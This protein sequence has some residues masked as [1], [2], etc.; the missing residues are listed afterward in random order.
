MKLRHILFIMLFLL[1][2]KVKSQVNT[3]P[4]KGKVIDASTG[5]GIADATVRLIKEHVT[6]KTSKDGVFNMLLNQD[7]DTLEVVA[8][9]YERI[10]IAVNRRTEFLNIPLAIQSM[11]LQE[12]LVNTGYQELK[13]NELTGA[14]VKIDERT[15]QQQTSTNILDRLD[16]VVSGLTFSKGKS[17]KNPQ[18]STNI[19]IRGLSTINGPLDPLIVLDGFIYEGDIQNI[20]PDDVQSIN[21]LKDAAAASIWG[22][23]AGNGVIVITTKQGRLNQNLSISMLSS[24]AMSP[25]ANLMALPQMSATDYIAVEQ[26]L[27]NKGYFNRQIRSTPYQA[28]TPAID[29]FQQRKLGLISTADSTAMIGRLKGIDSRKQYLDNFYTTPT[30]QQYQFSI[31]GG[32]V[33]NSYQ[34]S[35]SENHSIGDNY[36][37]FDKQN[38]H[39]GQQFLL[40]SRLKFNWRIQYTKSKSHSGRPAYNSLQINGR[41]PSYLSFRDENG[42]ELPLAFQYAPG[43]TDTTGTGHLLDWNYYPLQEFQHH[44]YQTSL[45]EIYATTAIHYQIFP[46]LNAELDY[47]QQHQSMD[48]RNLADAQSY[49]ARD[50]VNT[51]SQLNRTTGVVSYAIPVGGVLSTGNNQTYSY[52]GRFQLNLDHSWKK[53]RILALGGAEIREVS[54]NGQGNYYYGYQSDPLNYTQIDNVNRYRNWVTKRTSTIGSTPKL[55][56]LTNRFVS[57]YANA[58]YHYQQKY[59]LY[60]SIRRDGSNI[61]G[62]NTNDRWK[63]L[64][65]VGAVW[66]LSKENFYHFSS[67]P[68]LR[69]SGTWG[70]SGN[71]DLSRSALPVASYASNRYNQLPFIRVININNPGLKWEQTRQLNL[72]LDF[73]TK[74]GEFSGSI[75]YY[76]KK[77]TDLYGESPFDYTAW[78]RNNEIVKNVADLKGQGIDLTLNAAIITRQFKWNTNFLFSYNRNKVAAYYSQNALQYAAL[79]GEG[80]RITPVVGYPLYAIAAYK[81]AGLDNQGNPQGYLNGALSTDYNAMRLAIYKNGFDSGTM[82]YYGSAEPLYFGNLINNF[83]WKKWSMNINVGYKFD[84]YLFKPSISYNSLVN[85]GSVQPEFAQRWQHKGDENQTSVP[86]FTLPV[87][88]NRD[89]FY[90]ESQVNVLKGDHLRVNYINLSR[91]LNLTTGR[92]QFNGQVYLNISNPGILWRAN[93]AGVDPDY[94]GSMSPQQ[95]YTLGFRTQFK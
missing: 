40:G 35:V 48:A 66:D 77:G 85:N 6:N 17:N 74:G 8:L 31:R 61:F 84:Y 64:W 80:N 51:Y 55:T 36:E 33:K 59:I 43:Y 91:E 65:S 92:W 71:V 39:A 42:N 76:R 62:A 67:L 26:E 72:K 53:N 4:I 83:S 87:N 23:R 21:V 2:T 70:Y 10:K 7:N 79:L 12:V 54:Q 32:A 68:E 52:T 1:T 69:I 18:N 81:W 30:I 27:F 34:L 82:I 22:A 9:G 73:S 46:F 3:Y 47:Q 15:L 49:Q 41:K 13:S 56:Q 94:V 75:S 25:K 20:N 38:I 29:I 5:L 78:G 14:I 90:Q 58:S 89:A 16:G 63:P 86:S 57:Y 24:V 60:G 88:D 28:L 95:V 19:V 11:V 37:S 93:H 50:L 45:Q 44:S